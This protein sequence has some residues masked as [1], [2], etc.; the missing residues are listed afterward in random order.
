[1]KDWGGSM[2][3]ALAVLS[4]MKVAYSRMVSWPDSTA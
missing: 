3:L 2:T 1:M 4:G